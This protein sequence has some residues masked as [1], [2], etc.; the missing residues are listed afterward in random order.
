MNIRELTYNRR[1]LVLSDG[2]H[3]P[4]KALE[5]AN[6]FATGYQK[7]FCLLALCDN[8]DADFENLARQ[9][10]AAHA[11]NF[12]YSACSGDLQ[13]VCDLAERTETPIIFVETAKN[14]RF[15][16]IMPV[17][18][19][20]RSLRIPYVI[21]KSNGKDIDFSKV[22]VPVAFLP[23]EKEKAPYSCNMGRFLKSEI[24]VLQAKDYG[25]KTPANVRSI[26]TFY[27]KFELP[28]T[29]MPAKKDSYKVELEAVKMANEDNYGMV[30]I[31][32]SRDYGLDDIFFGPKELKLYKTSQVPLMCINPRG[33]L[34]VLCW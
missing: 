5:A 8:V 11:D 3:F 14:S 30:V 17:F 23:E 16:N 9:Y 34:Y 1:F 13:D 27:D 24:T 7:S 22:L 26:T 25:S 4:V 6:M 32:T 29:V 20:F 2:R 12:M 19:A 21:L 28:Y 10:E 15:S 33:D 31:S 18:K